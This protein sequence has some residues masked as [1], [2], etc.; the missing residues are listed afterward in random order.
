[1]LFFVVEYDAGEQH[2][3]RRVGE[4]ERCQQGRSVRPATEERAVASADAGS[5]YVTEANGQ[6]AGLTYDH[7]ALARARRAGAERRLWLPAPPA[8]G[9]RQPCTAP[10]GAQRPAGWA[11]AAKRRTR[12][13]WSWENGGKKQRRERRGLGAREGGWQ[14]KS[15]YR[16]KT[17]P[18]ELHLPGIRTLYRC[19]GACRVELPVSITRAVP[20]LFCFPQKDSCRPCVC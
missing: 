13:S 3:G 4:Q 6:P 5:A 16:M 12:R 14:G 17:M 10:R 15:K 18:V 9:P 7:H 2:R 20:Y 11:F 1:M 8:P 19:C